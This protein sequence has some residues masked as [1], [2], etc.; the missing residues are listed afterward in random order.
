[1]NSYKDDLPAEKT[2]FT[3][4]ITKWK[5]VNANSA[6]M[7]AKF[8]GDLKGVLESENVTFTDGLITDLPVQIINE[9]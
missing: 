8:K 5:L 1:M 9:R 2:D 4:E 6:I 3:L 7:S